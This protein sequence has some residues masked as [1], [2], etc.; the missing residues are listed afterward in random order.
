MSMKKI[1]IM[2]DME[3]VS[4]ELDW[5]NLNW[6]N[7]EP[8]RHGTSLLVGDLNA[9][10]EGAVQGGAEAIVVCDA[11][12]GGGNVRP[13]M[14]RAPAQLF[15]PRG[16]EDYL[17][18]IDSSFDCCFMI[19]SH[20]M[21]QTPGAHLA[22]TQTEEWLAYSING[23]ICG[24]IAQVAAIA[25]AHDVP[26][27]LVTGGSLAI[28]EARALLGDGT[29]YVVVKE[30]RLVGPP[31]LLPV[32]VAHDRI[33]AAAR[34]VVTEAGERKPFKISLPASIKLQCASRE[35]ADVIVRI[36]GAARIDE[37]TVEFTIQ[38]QGEVLGKLF[39]HSVWKQKDADLFKGCN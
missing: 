16:S 15:Y 32:E 10:I 4:G 38:R 30:D 35:F 19:G 39:E 8:H 26:I 21:A 33:R 36:S 34:R 2:S 31:K 18:E 29:D 13:G 23:K 9:A 17:P 6:R 27:G 14:L 5:A 24:E 28:A 37:F 7:K 1:Y 11:H 12:G 3:G 22:H 20:A 25:G